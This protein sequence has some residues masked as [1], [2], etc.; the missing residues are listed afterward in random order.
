MILRRMRAP[1][2]L[3][4]CIY[5]V[6][7]LGLVLIPGVDDNGDVWNMSFFHAFYFVSFTATTIGFGEIP[8]ALTEAQRLWALVTV[9]STVIAWFYSLGKIL[10]LIQDKAFRNAVATN[11][12]KNDI[13]DTNWY[14]K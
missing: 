2:L 9:Y 3:L 6:S 7:I 1:V 11:K 8:Y 5:S 4:I 13:N 14:M 12:F 10:G